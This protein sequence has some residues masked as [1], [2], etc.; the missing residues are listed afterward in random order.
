MGTWDELNYLRQALVGGLHDIEFVYVD[1]P[2]TEAFEDGD[3]MVVS[4]RHAPNAVC[5]NDGKVRIYITTQDDE[6]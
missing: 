4:G 5:I 6:D 2:K 1:N 3:I